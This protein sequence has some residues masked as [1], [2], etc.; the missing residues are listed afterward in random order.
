MLAQEQGLSDEEVSTRVL[1]MLEQG[2]NAEATELLKQAAKQGNTR[3]LVILGVF[4]RSGATGEVEL[5]KAIRIFEEAAERGSSEAD[6][7]LALMNLFGESVTP[8]A[9]K[10]TEYLT[11]ASTS[12]LAIAQFALG[13][14]YES[15]VGVQ[16]DYE[17]AI[18]QYAAA[19][20]QGFAKVGIRLICDADVSRLKARS[21]CFI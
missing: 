20:K 9:A 14:C 21:H 18:E 13:R 12:G 6:Y 4:Y 5:E 16:Q 15:G 11:K 7:Y 17:K 1:T 8:D 10:A 2:F 3:A 19:A